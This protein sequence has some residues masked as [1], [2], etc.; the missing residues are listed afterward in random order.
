M[1]LIMSIA[2]QVIQKAQSVFRGGDE[3]GLKSGY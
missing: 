1:K 2:N 3:N